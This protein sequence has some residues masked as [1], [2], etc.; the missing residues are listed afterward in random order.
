MTDEEAVL[1]GI[2]DMYDAFLARDRDR[3]D[4]HLAPTVTT[5]ESHLP[6]LMSRRELDEYRD[7]RTARERPD[8]ADLRVQPRAVDVWGD[9]ALARYVLVAVPRDA[10]APPVSTRVTD[11]LERTPSGWRIVHHHAE[12]QDTGT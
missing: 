5:W 10:G 1:D 2:R 3:F 8:P 7:R 11:V 6:D 12:R 9:R 4:R